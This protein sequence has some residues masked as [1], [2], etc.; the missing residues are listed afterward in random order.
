MGDKDIVAIKEAEKQYERQVSEF[1]E[2]HPESRPE[3][4]TISGIP[5]KRVYTPS[6]AEGIDYIKDIGFP[7]QYPYV[8]GL[9]PDGYR[10]RAWKI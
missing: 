8:R 6:D 1:L 2:M 4:K 7:G 3:Y 10:T 9:Y 5:L